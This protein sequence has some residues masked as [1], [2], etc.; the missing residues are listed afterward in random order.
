[1][2]YFATT[3]PEFGRDPKSLRKSVFYRFFGVYDLGMPKP[4]RFSFSMTAT[5]GIFYFLCFAAPISAGVF[6]TGSHVIDSDT[7]G[8][9]ASGDSVVTINAPADIG[10]ISAGGANRWSLRM[11][12]Q[13]TAVIHGGSFSGRVE[14]TYPGDDVSIDIYDGDFFGQFNGGG[15]I[16]IYGGNFYGQVIHGQG[17]LNVYGGNFQDLGYDSSDHPR[18]NVYGR[19]FD[20]GPGYAYNVNQA[21]PEAQFPL[22]QPGESFSMTDGQCCLSGA[23]VVGEYLDGSPISFHVL[24]DGLMSGTVNLIVVPEPS[25]GWIFLGAGFV[26]LNRARRER[27]S[28]SRR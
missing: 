7:D 9:F 19:R 15:R 17:E 5:V 4:A 27:R 18:V 21:Y 13:A 6:T 1:M 23:E 16:N 14:A 2:T 22:D 10:T 8:I 20:F 3:S 12:D 28:D 26:I 11:S 24:L 25:C